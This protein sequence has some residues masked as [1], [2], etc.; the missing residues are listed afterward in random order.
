[1]IMP[2]K[3]TTKTAA[4]KTVAKKKA[5]KVAAKRVSAR[6]KATKSA[7]G[8]EHVECVCKSASSPDECFWV[9]NGPVVDSIVHLKLALKDMTEEQF[10][11]HTTREGNDFAEWIRHC[12]KDE[13]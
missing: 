1:M 2:T 4:K 9:N 10:A 6:K 5:A 7:A 3:K 13:A 12:L 11:Y 8:C